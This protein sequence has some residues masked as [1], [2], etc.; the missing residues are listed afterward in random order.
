MCFIDGLDAYIKT[1]L[2]LAF[3]VYII[4][5]VVIVIIVSEYSPR[6]AQLIGKKDP[7]STLATLILLSYSKL[8]SLTITALS[9]AKLDYPDGKQE[10]VWLLDGN[11]KYFKGK[12]IP[13]VIVAVLIIL[14]GLPYTLLLFLWQWIVRAPRWKVFKWTRNTKLNGFITT[15]HVSHNS[16][17][18]YW[19]GFLLLVRVMLYLTASV[20][21]STNPQTFPLM[22]IILI[23]S[24]LLFSL[25]VYKNSLVN[26]MNTVLNFNLLSLSAFSQYDFKLDQKKQTAVAYT[27]TIITFI[28]FIGSI[29]YHIKLLHKKKTSPRGLN[30]YCFA[31]LQPA[32]AQVTYSVIELPKRDQD[33]QPAA[34][35]DRDELEISEDCRNVTPPY[36]TATNKNS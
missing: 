20:T 13:L 10:I 6:F 32:Y 21:V 17:Y 29:I 36:L 11:V 7:V 15:Y 33:T 27:S 25:R 26:F 16:K 24:L 12:H 5:L 14:I 30:E 1:W 18:R 3:T 34:D 31:P 28:L 9:F 22:S 8:L 2:Q 35:K 23:G 4:S 19:T